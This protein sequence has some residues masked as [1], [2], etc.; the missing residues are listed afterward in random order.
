MGIVDAEDTNPVMYPK[1]NDILH[2]FPE[3]L[4]VRIVEIQRIDILVLF[5]RIFRVLDGSGEQ[6]IAKSKAI[7]IPLA[8]TWPT[9]QSKSSS[10]PSSGSTALWPPNWLPIAYGTPGSLGSLV[11][12]LFFPLRFVKPI[13]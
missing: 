7:S 13:G 12:E 2:F 9:S 8:R 1:E 6:L 10:V 3:I 4:R 5:G 11:T